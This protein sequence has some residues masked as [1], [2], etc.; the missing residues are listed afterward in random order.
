MK[1]GVN[2]H[3][4]L[5]SALDKQMSTAMQHVSKAV[6]SFFGIIPISNLIVNLIKRYSEKFKGN[7][8]DP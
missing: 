4:A 2:E 1:P 8:C 5:S 3:C 6:A 7:V